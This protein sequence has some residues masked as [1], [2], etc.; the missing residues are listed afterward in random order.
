M[1]RI[2]LLVFFLSC[3]PE[4]D[5]PYDPNS[6]FFK[7]KTTLSGLCQNRIGVPIPDCWIKVLPLRGNTVY[8]TKTDQ[9]GRYELKDCPA[10][11]VLIIGE[12]EGFVPESVFTYLE[13]YKGETINFILEGLPKFVNHS[14]FSFFVSR[15]IP[16]DSSVLSLKCELEDPE[17]IG[18]IKKVF[19]TIEGLS[20][21]LPLAF[22]FGST[23]EN[24]FLEESLSQNLEEISGREFYLI[25][26]DLFGHYVQ[27]SPLRL[28]RVI[29][30]PPEPISPAGGDSVSCHPL[31]VWQL[32]RY[33][34]SYSQFI[35]I[36]LIRPNLEPILYLRS[37]NIPPGDT[38]FFVA[39][40]LIDGYYYWQVGIK[41]SYNNWAKSAEAVFRVGG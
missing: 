8:L 19:A 39:E 34:F 12:K 23:Y 7:K 41:D 1:K 17:G 31:L 40:S 18:D 32:P 4:R 37:E 3:L 6:D 25:A 20:D 27:S 29:R 28:I 5:N 15:H 35:E 9:R 14:L 16:R 10:E 22:K 26:S 33:L 2:F 38:S 36:Y 30:N 24:F 21:T 11:S 13:V